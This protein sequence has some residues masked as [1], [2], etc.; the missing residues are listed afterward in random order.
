MNRGTVVG[1]G[2]TRL[3][4]DN[5]IM[6]YCHLAHDC[7]VGNRT[8]F[9]NCASLAG[10]VTVGDFAILGGFTIVHQFCRLGAHCLT[11]LGTGTLKDIPP[12][13][14]AS[15]NPAAPHGLNLRGLKRRQFSDVQIHN[16][17]RAYKL[18]YKSELRLDEAQAQLDVLSREQPE[19]A[20]LADFIRSSERG[21]IR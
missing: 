9:A 8:I 11:A 4:N 15:G 2:V 10:H 17:R 19:V 1:G 20:V 7:H 12:Y 21:L 18:L 5:F 6:A 13:V 3:G 16:L 14:I